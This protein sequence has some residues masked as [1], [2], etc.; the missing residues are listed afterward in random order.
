MGFFRVI[1]TFRFNQYFHAESVIV[2]PQN[3]G[4]ARTTVCWKLNAGRETKNF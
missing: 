4:S 3:N 1:M 2:T